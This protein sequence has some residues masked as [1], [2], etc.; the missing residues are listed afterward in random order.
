MDFTGAHSLNVLLYDQGRDLSEVIHQFDPPHDR[1]SSL[2]VKPNTVWSYFFFVLMH[3]L[4]AIT[5]KVT[6]HTSRLISP[7]ALRE[8]ALLLGNGRQFVLLYDVLV[9]GGL[10]SII[11]P[12]MCLPSLSVTSLRPSPSFLLEA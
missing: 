10:C 9:E 6:F 12:L 4:Y 3:L 8:P 7:G 1:W 11:L 2:T 5:Y